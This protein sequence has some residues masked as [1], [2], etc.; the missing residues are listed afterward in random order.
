MSVR[1]QQW[2]AARIELDPATRWTLWHLADFAHEDGTAAFPSARRLAER[3]GATE[4]TVRRHLA[5]L[6]RLRFIEDGDQLLTSHY[7]TNR[8]PHVWDLRLNPGQPSALASAGGPGPVDNSRPGVS[9]VAPQD[10]VRGDTGGIT[11][12]SYVSPKP[13]TRERTTRAR[14]RASTCGRPDCADPDVGNGPGWLADDPITHLP[15]P[16]PTCR[17]PRRYRARYAGQRL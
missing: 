17:P 6:V 10:G 1:A 7:Q 4:R 16:C 14:A 9:R 15:R 12:V 3:T 13:S 5:E 11:G 8:R 2:A